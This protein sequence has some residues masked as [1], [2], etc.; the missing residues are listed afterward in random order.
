LATQFRKKTLWIKFR[1]QII[2]ENFG[3]KKRRIKVQ[4]KNGTFGCSEV[5]RQLQPQ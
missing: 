1:K 2:L 4:K 5:G 3:M